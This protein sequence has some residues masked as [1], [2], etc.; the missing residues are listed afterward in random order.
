MLYTAKGAGAL[1]VP[2]AAGIAKLHGWGAVF[3]IAMSFNV[4]AGFL[5]LFV[6]RPMRAR[7]FARGREAHANVAGTPAA[8]V[9]PETRTT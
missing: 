3:S 7:H 1:L 6:L 4:I 5:A 8:R 2:V 9:T